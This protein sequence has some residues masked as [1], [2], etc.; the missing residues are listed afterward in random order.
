MGWDGREL[1]VTRKTKRELEYVMAGCA[2][3]I[4]R[5]CFHTCDAFTRTGGRRKS[6]SPAS[7]SLSERDNPQDRGAG[8]LAGAKHLLPAKGAH[9]GSLWDGGQVGPWSAHINTV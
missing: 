7:S 4:L 9:P 1:P 2:G 5:S 6:I 8:G 3:C